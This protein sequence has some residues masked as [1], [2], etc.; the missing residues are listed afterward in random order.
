MLGTIL[1]VIFLLAFALSQ[2]LPALGISA[3]WVAVFAVAAALGILFDGV[4]TWRK[5]A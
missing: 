3:T 4:R 2:L 1:L 5:V